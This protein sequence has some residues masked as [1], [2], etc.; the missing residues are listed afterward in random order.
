MKYTSP[1]LEG[2]LVKRY[3]RFLADIYLD[4]KP[5]TVHCPNSGSMAGL[6]ETGNRIRISGPHNPNR[7]LLYTLEQVQIRRPDGRKLWV[8]VNTMIPNKVAYESIKAGKIPGLEKYSSV[9]SEVKLN[10]GTR[11]D[12]FLESDNL[13][14]C[15]VEVKNVTLVMEDPASK[16][17]LNHGNI[18][19]FPDAVTDRGAK[20]LRELSDRVKAGER[21][22]MLY[23]IQRSD[24]ETFA[25]AVS[26]D[27]VYADTLK[28]A[29]DIGVEIIPVQARVA[30]NGVTMKKIVPFEI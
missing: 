9:R 7:K 25:P 13:P 26:Y 2:K 15:W 10:K 19:C 4:G 27:T 18:A 1:L 20:H 12:L 22:V 24:G 21:A 17:T 23:V 28:E 5:M 29:I 3:K 16:E 30:K 8:G 11:L 14:P 6:T